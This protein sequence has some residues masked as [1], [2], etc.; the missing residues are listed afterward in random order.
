MNSTV[1]GIA[2]TTLSFNKTEKVD[3]KRIPLLN[4]KMMTDEEWNRLAYQNYLERRATMA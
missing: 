3:V 4:I 1:K 2:V